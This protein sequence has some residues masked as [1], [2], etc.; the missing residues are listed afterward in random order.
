VPTERM[1]PAQNEAQ[2]RGIRRAAGSPSLFFA[3][4]PARSLGVRFGNRAF[5]GRFLTPLPCLDPIFVVI[6]KQ[7]AVLAVDFVGPPKNLCDVQ[8]IGGPCTCD[9]HLWRF[10]LV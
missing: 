9:T 2:R 10:K 8:G 7:A 1:Y 4:I 6:T 3:F 5:F